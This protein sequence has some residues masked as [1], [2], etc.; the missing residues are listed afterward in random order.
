MTGVVCEEDGKN[1]LFNASKGVILATGDY[2]CDLEMVAYYCPDI[3]D[4]PPC[5]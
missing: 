4:V 5:R 3:K 1:V 2:Q